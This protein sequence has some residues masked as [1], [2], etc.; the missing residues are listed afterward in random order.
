MSSSRETW[1]WLHR[2]TESCKAQTDPLIPTRRPVSYLNPVQEGQ[3]HEHGL[4]G[5]SDLVQESHEQD[6]SATINNPHSFDLQGKGKGD[7]PPPGVVQS[8]PTYLSDAENGSSSF[9]ISSLR[10]FLMREIDSSRAVA[11]LTAYCFMTGFIDVV[12]FSAI[13]VWCAFQTG[14]S[15]QLAL[16]LARFFN[17]P[18]NYSF[19]LSD[20]QALCSILSFIFG[21]FI[22]RL[23]D[24]I[25]C[26]TRLWVTLGTF[27]QTMFTTA[28][29]IAIWKSGQPSIS[30]SRAVSAWSNTLSFVCIGFMSASMGLQGIMGKRLNTE[31]ATT[32][33]LTV[34]WCEL[35]TEPQLFHFRR[36]VQARNHKAMAILSLFIGAFM[37]RA[38]LDKIGSAG[39]LAVGAGIRF[40]ITLSWLFVPAKKAPKN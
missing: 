3:R 9:K 7:L 17:S 10:Q 13:F 35:V 34:T 24:R 40:L 38:I 33:V 31:F 16:A 23:G 8:G 29:A 12:S 25:G 5:S 32:I 19:H 1:G 20:R 22:G 15:L 6:A 37:G 21:A 2:R 26:R 4:E 27:I 14:N 18:H 30:D 39:T 28:A 36:P 11:P